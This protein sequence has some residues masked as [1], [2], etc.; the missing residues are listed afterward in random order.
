MDLFGE[1]LGD[2]FSGN[3]TNTNT[4][5]LTTDDVMDLF[6][7]GL[8]DMFS[9]DDKMDWDMSMNHTDDMWGNHTDDMWGNYTDMNYT[10]DMWGNYTYNES[11]WNQTWDQTWD[12]SLDFND[13]DWFGALVNADC[14]DECYQSDCGFGVQCWVNQCRDICTNTTTCSQDV[15]KT[16]DSEWENYDCSNGIVELK[17]EEECEYTECEDSEYEV[18][19]EENCFDGCGN[20][21]C[22]VWFQVDGDWYGQECEDGSAFADFRPQD[23][24]NGINQIGLA[25]GDTIDSLWDLFCDPNDPQCTQGR[26]DL[27]AAFNGRTTNSQQLQTPSANETAFVSQAVNQVVGEVWTNFTQDVLPMV[28]SFVGDIFTPEVQGILDSVK[29]D[30]QASMPGADLQVLDVLTNVNSTDALVQQAESQFSLGNIVNSL[31]ALVQ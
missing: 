15:L 20:N 16:W 19:W 31:D 5:D 18:C 3:D 25:Y 17:C 9:G 14:Q 8:G 1:N 2:M 24:I 13:T 6:G 12:D 29:N 23:L 26:Q 7:D 28:N 22:S 11:D 4:T 30:T 21:N 27:D 10:D